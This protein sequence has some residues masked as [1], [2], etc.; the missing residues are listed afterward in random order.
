MKARKQMRKWINRV[1]R[2]IGKPNGVIPS[3]AFDFG[4]RG[5]WT[6][7]RAKKPRYQR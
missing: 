2:K 3:F 5:P 1:R 4:S 7:K 6:D